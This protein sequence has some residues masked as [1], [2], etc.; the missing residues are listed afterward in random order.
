LELLRPFEK[1]IVDRFTK[2]GKMADP[3][4]GVKGWKGVWIRGHLRDRGTASIYGMWSSWTIFISR[5]E[6]LGAIITPGTYQGFCTYVYILRRLGLIR[7]VRKPELI[8]RVMISLGKGLYGELREHINKYIEDPM[9][10]LPRYAI[11]PGRKAPRF[12]EV[13]PRKINDPA[14]MRPLQE[15]YPSTDWTILSKEEKRMRRTRYKRGREE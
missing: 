11:E 1:E 8:F 4:R 14:W 6:I 13:V 15:A 7:E 10:K 2:F 9:A 3:V 12:Y 5:A